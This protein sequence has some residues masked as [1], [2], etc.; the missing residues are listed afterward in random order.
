M[1]SQAPKKSK[2]KKIILFSIIGFI[3]FI[4]LFLIFTSSEEII[5][6]VQTEKVAKRD[7]TQV[8]TSTGKIKPVNQVVLR[9][10]VSGEIVS[11][12]IK[13]GDRVRK[14]QLLLQ[15]KSDIYRAQVNK[16]AANLEY[17]K[18]NLK[19]R[20]AELDKIQKEY[21]RVKELFEK[22]LAS[23]SEFETAQA[24][25]LSAEGM[26][27]AQQSAVMQSE[28]SLREAREELAKTTIRSPMDGVITSLQVEPNERVLGSNFSVGTELMTVANLDE[29][30]ATIEVDENDVVLISIGDTAKIK[31]DAFGEL[32]FLGKVTEIGNSAI[33]SNLGTQ[34]QVINFEVKILLLD[35]GDKVRPGM[36]CDADIMTETKPSVLSVPLQSVTARM[37]DQ[38]KFE[39]NKDTNKVDNQENTEKKKNKPI[40]I[41]FINKNGVATAIPVV[42]GI[43]DDEYIEIVNGL[44]GTEEVITGPYR[45]ISKE[46][47]DGSKISVQKG[48]KGKTDEN[49]EE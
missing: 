32:E 45:S 23:N 20:K 38:L 49:E 17:S 47:E 31:I 41:V 29:M 12:P 22:G 24:N 16:A 10:E 36:S 35:A 42:T 46:L 34:D 5:L 14:G 19:I 37:P 28:E 9:P 40:E 15:I 21:D 7:I 1:P 26:Y 48:N 44:D 8:V 27:E 39:N 43:S 33:T 6:S 11:L 4:L 30:E 3:V 2:K 25:F 13:E 18:A